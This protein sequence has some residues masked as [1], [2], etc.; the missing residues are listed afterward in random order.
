MVRPFVLNV[1]VEQK[2]EEQKYEEQNGWDV[3]LELYEGQTE[4][5]TTILARHFCSLASKHWENKNSFFEI[6]H[7]LCIRSGQGI[8]WKAD[9]QDP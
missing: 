4:S 1:N 7:I 3:E 2:Y 5:K 6:F 8:Y 9:L